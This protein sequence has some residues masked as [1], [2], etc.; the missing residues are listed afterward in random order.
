M[1]CVY[2]ELRTVIIYLKYLFALTKSYNK[3]F[4][5]DKLDEMKFDTFYLNTKN[6]SQT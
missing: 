4:Q 3:Y 2:C 5:C 1:N 6:Y